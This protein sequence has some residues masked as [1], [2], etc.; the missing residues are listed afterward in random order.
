MSFRDID[1]AKTCLQ[2]LSWLDEQL[3]T[4]L[5]PPALVSAFLAH[6]KS[7][8]AWQGEA[9]IGARLT[10]TDAITDAIARQ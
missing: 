7:I 10:P 6:R 9:S 1:D 8:L 2:F 3:D 4:S 5:P